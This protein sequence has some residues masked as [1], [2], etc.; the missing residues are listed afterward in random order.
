MR[1]LQSSPS[2]SGSG[3]GIR[4]CS[5]VVAPVCPSASSHEKVKDG[6]RP[7]RGRE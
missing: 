1:R 3:Y 6:T 7:C 2:T 4:S 5:T